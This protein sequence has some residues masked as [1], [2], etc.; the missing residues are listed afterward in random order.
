MDSLLDDVA[1]Q[2]HRLMQQYLEAESA[3]LSHL[4]QV[5]SIRSK[6]ATVTVA[7]SEREPGMLLSTCPAPILTQLF[8]PGHGRDQALTFFFSEQ[9]CTLE[10]TS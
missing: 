2:R 10:K 3:G 4:D 7:A 9:Q 1:L 8:G 6:V 5:D